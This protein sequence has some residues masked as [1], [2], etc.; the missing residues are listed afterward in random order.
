MEIST[1]THAG[2]L[3]VEVGGPELTHDVCEEFRN[4]VLPLLENAPARIVF[5]LHEVAFMDSLGIGSLI[6]VRNRAIQNQGGVALANITRKVR[7]LLDVT[8][9]SKIFPI[10]DSVE[11]AVEDVRGASPPMASPGTKQE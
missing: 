5:D 4:Q 7:K 3:V 8:A 10:H 9:L 2:V 11:A 1:R 6:T